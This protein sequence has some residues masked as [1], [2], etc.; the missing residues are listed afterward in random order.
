MS[1]HSM[2][3]E[4]VM[5]QICASADIL[6]DIMLCGRYLVNFVMANI[7]FNP[8]S[9]SVLV[10]YWYFVQIVFSSNL[11]EILEYLYSL[12]PAGSPE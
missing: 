2:A 6:V 11:G 8:T 7:Y 5:L 12:K 3:A 4:C 10:F 9:C 1:M